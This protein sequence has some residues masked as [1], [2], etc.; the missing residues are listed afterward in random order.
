MVS[1]VRNKFS[2]RYSLPDTLVII[3]IECK[4]CYDLFSHSMHL[5]YLCYHWLSIVE[6]IDQWQAS[7][8]ETHIE[9]SIG[10]GKQAFAVAGQAA[11]NSLPTEFRSINCF[12]TFKSYLVILFSL[13]YL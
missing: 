3:Y 12:T 2:F 9:S 4:H 5:F 10:Y 11:W 13:S 8:T 6:C 1:V 7:R